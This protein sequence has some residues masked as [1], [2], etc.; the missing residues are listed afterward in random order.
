MQTAATGFESMQDS[1]DP[2]TFAVGEADACRMMMPD[3][4]PWA[5]IS[6]ETLY[7]LTAVS[8][9]PP[10]D[11]DGIA[12]PAYWE[13][14]LFELDKRDPEA[15]CVTAKKWLEAGVG[16]GWTHCC[17][18]QTI[19]ERD[20]V[21]AFA[22]IHEKGT[23][24]NPA[25]LANAIEAHELQLRTLCHDAAD[26]GSEPTE[27]QALVTRR[28]WLVDIATQCRSR[29]NAQSRFY[30]KLNEALCSLDRYLAES[31]LF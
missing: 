10:C 23:G 9:V 15:A 20:E 17:A 5:E 22:F 16:D 14:A 29:C 27:A 11:E 24:C 4:V 7:E 26:E 3:D 1:S 13:Y 21:Y 18:W 28:K 2:K 25:L 8:E 30:A 6:L 31:R 12:G 19:L